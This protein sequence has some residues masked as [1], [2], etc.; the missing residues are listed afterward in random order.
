MGNDDNKNWR[1][2]RTRETIDKTFQ[3]MI[4]EMDANALNVKN[5]SEGAGFNRKTFYLHYNCIEDLF[6]HTCDEICRSYSEKMPLSEL[7]SYTEPNDEEKVITL[8]S[9]G[10]YEFFTAQDLYVERLLCTPSYYVWG[11]RIIDTCADINRQH[12]NIFKD[13]TEEEKAL[14]NNLTAVSLFNTYR[15][16]V[17]LGKSISID[18]LVEFSKKYIYPRASGIFVG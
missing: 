7:D 11:S 17:A 8:F 10:F 5:I 18:T 3:Q 14:F 2:A 1:A 9:R 6:Q 12:R 15:Q 13:M 16:W 4:C